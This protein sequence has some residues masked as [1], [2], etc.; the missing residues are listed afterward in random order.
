M[1]GSGIISSGMM[2]GSRTGYRMMGS[3]YAGTYPGYGK[4]ASYGSSLVWKIGWLLYVALAASVFSLIFWGVKRWFE[5]CCGK[6][7]H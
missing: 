2:Y 1:M 7:K 6:K 4:L 3:G 5:G